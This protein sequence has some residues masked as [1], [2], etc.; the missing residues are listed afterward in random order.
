M[1][2]S[3]MMIDNVPRPPRRG[4][5]R[6][7]AALPLIAAVPLAG[8]AAVESLERLKAM[9]LDELMSVEVTTVSRVARPLDATAAAVFVIGREDIRRSGAANIPELLRMVP[10]LHVARLNNNNYAVSA[11]GFSGRFAEKLLV[12]MDGRTL[13][14]PLFAGVYWDVQETPLADV[15]RIEVI[16]GPG[17]AIWGSNAVNGVINIITR[18]AEETHGGE[19]HLA[20]SSEGR[21]E[22]TLRYG[23]ALGE[24]FHY[25][26]FG[27]GLEDG[28]GRLSTGEIGHDYWR[29][30]RLGFRVDGRGRGDG[31]LMVE[32]AHY[33]SKVGRDLVMPLSPTPMGDPGRNQGYHLLARW[34]DEAGRGDGYEFQVYFD[35][36]ERVNSSL[37]QS[38]D[39]L[40]LDYQR[41]LPWGDGNTLIWGAGYRINHDEILSPAGSPLS[42]VPERRR[43]ALASLF[44]QN[45]GHFLDDRL[46]VVVGAKF[47]END[48][49]GGEFMPNLRMSWSVADQHTLWGAVTRAVR[50][51]S[52]MESDMRIRQ[53]P[54]FVEGNPGLESERLNAFELGYRGR[55]AE[56]WSLDVAAF[57][58]DYD[59]LRSSE[60]VVTGPTPTSPPSLIHF[61]NV[62]RISARSYGIEASAT[63]DPAP[64]WRLT[65]GYGWFQLDAAPEAT[66]DPFR[67]TEL[68]FTPEHQFSLRSRY[69][70]TPRVELDASLYAFSSI[71]AAGVSSHARLDLRL[72]WRIDPTLELSL[73]VENLLDDRHRELSTSANENL[74]TTDVERNLYARLRWRF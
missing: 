21:D 48:Y 3:K 50:S 72:G 20:L 27:K 30:R 23:G 17:A 29:D 51:P 56:R 35:A 68:D 24:R 41:Y 73:G 63:W 61:V 26:L 34:S 36:S 4:V 66:S 7:V 52:R 47:E 37:N 55:P 62:N 59:R 38:R 28:P 8:E 69:D 25:R 40:D 65:A 53:F 64:D 31:R 9:S 13:Y 46:S 57:V 15:E 70:W 10:G 2:G 71:P 33:R 32:G 6:L 60:R 14:T 74:V 49:S 1:K 54:I 43:D 58:N 12:M 16:R 44:A 22:G 39:I 5:G 42:V 18:S 19:L 11:R 67:L 45:E